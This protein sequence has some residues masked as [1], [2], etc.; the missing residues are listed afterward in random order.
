MQSFLYIRVRFSLYTCR[1]FYV[2][3]VFSILGYHHRL[4]DDGGIQ[5]NIYFEVSI[6][7]RY[8]WY[9]TYS[10]FE[11]NNSW[12]GGCLAHLH[13]AST[14]FGNLYYSFIYA[15]IGN[16]YSCSMRASIQL[17]DFG[18]FHRSML[19]CFQ[20]FF[21]S[22]LPHVTKFTS[23]LTFFAVKIELWFWIDT[24]PFFEFGI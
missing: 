12:Y 17:I 11:K 7:S 8:R 18:G 16:D 20:V 2:N 13:F 3:F 9:L 14:L 23:T 1:V 4:T 22:T 15:F 19:F 21:Q 6:C 24:K 10:C 5:N